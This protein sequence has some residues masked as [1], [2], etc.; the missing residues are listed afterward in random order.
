MPMKVPKQ[1][2]REH[3]TAPGTGNMASWVDREPVTQAGMRSGPGCDSVDRAVLFR[4]K[5]RCRGTG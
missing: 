3:T 5:Y 1:A 4:Y 2:S